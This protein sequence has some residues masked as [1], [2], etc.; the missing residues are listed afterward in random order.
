MVMVSITRVSIANRPIPTFLIVW[1]QAL[2]LIST[3]P[4]V[5]RSD[6]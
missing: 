6:G 1:A 2:S 3:E 4:G 5:A